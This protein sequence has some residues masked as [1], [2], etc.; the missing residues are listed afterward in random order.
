MWEGLA[1]K[2]GYKCWECGKS[3]LEIENAG[4]TLEKH[5]LKE[6]VNGGYDHISNLRLVCTKCHENMGHAWYLKKNKKKVGGE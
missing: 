5:H 6:L 2:Y 4:M 1:K 3:E